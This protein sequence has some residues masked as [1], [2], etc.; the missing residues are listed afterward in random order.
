MMMMS[1][2]ILLMHVCI[3]NDFSVKDV[4]VCKEREALESAK[5]TLDCKVVELEQEL[6]TQRREITAGTVLSEL[7]HIQ[8]FY[9]GCRS[10]AV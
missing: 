7:L 1:M 10:E 6:D 3:S 2:L 4:E 9:D 5:R 8:C